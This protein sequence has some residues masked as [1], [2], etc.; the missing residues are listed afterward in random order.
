MNFCTFLAW[1]THRIGLIGENHKTYTHIISPTSPHIR[2][3]YIDV[4]TDLLTGWGEWRV[5][6]IT[7]AADWFELRSLSCDQMQLHGSYSTCLFHPMLHFSRIPYD[8]SSYVHYYQ[9]Q[10]A[11][12]KKSVEKQASWKGWS[13]RRGF[14][15]VAKCHRYG[16]L[17]G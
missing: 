13:L 7:G 4:R 6:Q 1:R 10:G 11:F 5:G 15:R 3:N 17:L 16:T 9:L 12:W 2:C 8:C 14:S